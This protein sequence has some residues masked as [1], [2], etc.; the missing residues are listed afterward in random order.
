MHDLEG[1]ESTSV[2]RN[3]HKVQA[4]RG[5]NSPGRPEIPP[6]VFEELFDNALVHRDYLVSATI[7]LF[8]FDNRVEIIS[9][10]H[11]PNNLTVERI[12]AG[13]SNIRNPILV[14]YVAKGLL[15]Y[16]GLGSGIKR[17][18]DAWPAIAFTDDRDG[19]L[20]TATI[21]RKQKRG[22]GKGSEEKPKSSEESSE[23]NPEKSSEKI[24]VLLKKRPDVTAREMATTLKIS[25][26]AVE[27]HL[28][29]LKTQ[30]RIRRIGPTKGGHW[31]VLA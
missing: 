21:Q 17:A 19:C 20:F 13:I 4:G 27:K 11:L 28:E 24:L 8:I 23:E 31:E 25:P 18:M 26:R 16:K 30:G 9:P 6:S 14:S 10:G 7:R 29:K 2:M 1:I 12:L 15:P 22:S 3:L 5:V